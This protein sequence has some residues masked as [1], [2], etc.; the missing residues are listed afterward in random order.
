MPKPKKAAQGPMTAAEMGR[1]SRRMLTKAQRSESAK[2]AA[3]ARW[4][5]AKAQA[6]QP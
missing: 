3:D 2:R 1:R 4:A 6:V 5:K